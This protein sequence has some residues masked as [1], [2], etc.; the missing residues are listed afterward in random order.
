[1]KIERE[2]TD[3]QKVPFFH[4]AATT[5]SI[6]N[7][8]NDAVAPCVHCISMQARHRLTALT[9]PLLLHI[10]AAEWRERNGSSVGVALVS[11]ALPCLLRF[12]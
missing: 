10:S 3:S 2:M 1:M 9:S 4:I 11:T 7:S 5:Y 6:N 12:L 8:F